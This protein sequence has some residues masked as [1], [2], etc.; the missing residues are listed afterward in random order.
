MLY[1][2]VIRGSDMYNRASVALQA[3]KSA[4]VEKRVYRQRSNLRLPRVRAPKKEV[5]RKRN[6]K[7]FARNS[8]KAPKTA[9]GKRNLLLPV[10]SGYKITGTSRENMAPAK[11]SDFSP[12]LRFT[13]ANPRV[14][15]RGTPRRERAIVAELRNRRRIEETKITRAKLKV[16]VKKRKLFSLAKVTPTVSAAS[17]AQPA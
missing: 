10:S 3:G 2:G 17:L 4:L 6:P 15:E 16:A 12:S 5:R 14:W 1:P 11:I 9:A 13:N 7:L 8:L